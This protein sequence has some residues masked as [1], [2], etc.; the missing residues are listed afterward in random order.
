MSNTPSGTVGETGKTTMS[1]PL[2][3][4]VVGNPNCGKTTLF[5]ALTGSRQ[6]VGNWPGV[7][8]ERK[9]G[10]YRFE[11]TIVHLVDLPG[12]YSLD[13]SDHDLSLDERIA[14]DF[15]H[16]READLVLN[17]LDAAN[18]ERNL[19]L[20]TQLI[21]MGRPL[22]V[23]LN[24]MDVARERGIKIDV[25]ALTK[26]LGCPVVP[27]SAA[28]GEGIADLKR[29]LL[30]SQATHPI[31]Q[32]EIPYQPLLEKAIAALL[33][34][35]APIARE[36]GDSPR[37]LSARLLE[38]DDLAQRLV[39]DQVAP[40]EVRALL[41]DQADDLDILVA[42]ARYSFAHA[43]TQASVT[44]VGAVSRNLSDRIDRVMLNRMLGIPIFLVVMYLMFMFTI[45]IG[46]AFIDC[47]RP[48][49]RH[50][51][52]GRDGPYPCRPGC[53]RVAGP[54]AGRR[55]RR[56]HPG[57]GDLHPHHRASSTSSCRSWR[58]RATWPAPPSSWIASCAPSDCRASPSYRS[59]S[60]SAATCRRS[61]QPG[62]WRTNVTGH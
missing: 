24:M 33:P 17:I 39:G 46:G 2:T 21:E 35:V 31:P 48:S 45:N 5:N 57:G 52:R 60:A 12:T 18:L 50:P 15:I 49:R 16:A 27:I 7:T 28:T 36:N 22:V 6:R 55:H 1:K 56:R 59:W 41:G 13:V 9:I 37:W 62:P 11:G 29:V 54:A 30:E 58:T 3:I 53:T 40:G 38:G 10:R 26:R 42:D 51:L 47:L 34:R 8:V 25:D 23:A 61:W 4:G 43:M 14:R 20:T 19:Y 44:K 32:V